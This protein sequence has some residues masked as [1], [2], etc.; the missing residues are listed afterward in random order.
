MDTKIKQLV[1]AL[2]VAAIYGA[3]GELGFSLAISP[4]NITAVWPPSGVAVAAWLLRGRPAIAGV[5]LGSFLLNLYFYHRSGIAP[6]TGV[7]LAII[8][9]AGSTAQAAALTYVL[10]KTVDTQRLVSRPHDACLF[11][12][13]AALCCVIAATIG[14]ASSGIAGLISWQRFGYTWLTWW[15]GDAGGILVFTP[16][17]LAWRRPPEFFKQPAR[18]VEFG[19]LAV[20]L[21]ALCN[22]LFGDSVPANEHRSLLYLVFPVLVWAAG[23]FGLSAVTMTIVVVE[24]FAI[25]GIKAGRGQF[26]A[27]STNES[28]LLIALFMVT[29]SLVGLTFACVLNEWA[30]L[31]RKLETAA[32]R[33]N[34]EVKERTAELELANK[35][36]QI[37]RDRA[38]EAA[39]A[40]S[41]FI[42]NIS[43]ELRT[44]LTGILGINELLLMEEQSVERKNL[45]QMMYESAKALLSV[46]NDILDLSKIESGKASIVR[47]P[48][49]ITFLAQDCAKLLAPSAAAKGLAFEV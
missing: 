12:G 40:K 4:G 27:A 26:V 7:L 28:L 36:L 16:F 24:L 32:E 3:M 14:V 6:T 11:I 22:L 20:T 44:P 15:A 25:L 48:F 35:N 43:H 31:R 17:I 8:I 5:W 10:R 13:W 38:V 23:R 41:A 46:V 9:A 47:E 39:N 33:A 2:F 34:S 37:A 19:L 1:E 30:Q 18:V 21:I 45:L 42:A 49:N 29:L